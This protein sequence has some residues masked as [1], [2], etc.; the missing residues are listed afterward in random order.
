[1]IG[2]RT[3]VIILFLLC[4]VP[5]I[6]SSCTRAGFDYFENPY[7]SLEYSDH[8]KYSYYKLSEKYEESDNLLSDYLEVEFTGWR[9]SLI[10]VTIQ[11]PGT[12][13]NGNASEIFETIINDAKTSSDSYV[14][15]KKIVDG[16]Q[17]DYLK[18]VCI[19]DIPITISNE[20]YQQSKT[21]LI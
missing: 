21:F 13:T 6:I 4:L 19:E 11:H 20:E 16:I 17:A 3:A 18:S 9:R 14:T 5:I 1:M 7:F 15:G 10:K 12:D 2:A 8:Y